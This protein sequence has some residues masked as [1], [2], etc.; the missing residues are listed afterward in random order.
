MALKVL[1]V[2]G[3]AAV[4]IIVILLIPV[5]L[6][7][8]RTLDEA[9]IIISETRPQTLTLLKRVQATLDSVNQEL[10][11]IEFITEDTSMLVSKVG[12]ASAA[13]EKAIKS[14]M[15]KIG[16]VTAGAVATGFAVKRRLSR[17]L[18]DKK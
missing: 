12:D 9:S 13:V 10:S 1:Q 6:R 8:R 3:A 16:F 7:L 4:V 5:L 11:S 15:T 2:V 17:D 18:S 14:P